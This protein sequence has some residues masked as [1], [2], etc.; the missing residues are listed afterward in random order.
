[1][2]SSDGKEV[3]GWENIE[4]ISD[5]P[6][7]V[8]LEEFKR[9]KAEF[10][11]RVLIASIMEEYNQAAVSGSVCVCAGCGGWGWRDDW[12]VGW[13]SSGW[14]CGGGGGGNLLCVCVCCTMCT[15]VCVCVLWAGCLWWKARA[16]ASTSSDRCPRDG[17]RPSCL[18]RRCVRAL[19]AV[20]GAD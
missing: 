9:L 14:W 20:G 15:C 11:D 2:K 4:L 16:V 8:M 3:I 17:A 12:A 13:K 6:L 18:L 10:P 19:G 1:M 7:E 5:R